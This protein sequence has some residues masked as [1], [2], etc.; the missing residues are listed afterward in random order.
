MNCRHDTALYASGQLWY[1]PTPNLNRRLL[2]EPSGPFICP[3]CAGQNTW[4]RSTKTALFRAFGFSDSLVGAQCADYTI[5]MAKG[6]DKRRLEQNAGHLHKLRL[7]I[8]AANVRD[9]TTRVLR[10]LP[11]AQR[12]SC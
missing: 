3:C 12:L 8:A 11:A 9:A 5:I 2:I 10:R 4:P 1:V 6:G 7:L